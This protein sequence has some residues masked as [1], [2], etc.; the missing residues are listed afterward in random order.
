MASLSP[1]VQVGMLHLP[2]WV[3]V[4]F[5][6]VIIYFS[7]EEWKMLEKWQKDLYWKVLKDNY[8]V[9]VLVG[10]PVTKADVLAWL[11][12]HECPNGNGIQQPK[13]SSPSEIL[14]PSNQRL[15]QMCHK[16][17]IEQVGSLQELCSEVKADTALCYNITGSHSQR[18]AVSP[19]EYESG[20][21]G[22][23]SQLKSLPR[24]RPRVR[25]KKAFFPCSK[26]KKCFSSSSFLKV[27]QR[28]HLKE[29]GMYTHHG[30][31]LKTLHCCTDCGQNFHRYLD[32]LQHRKSHQMANPWLC[33]HCGD[34]FMSQSD[35]AMHEKGHL[36]E[37]NQDLA[38]CSQ[39]AICESSETGG[40]QMGLD[41]PQ[42]QEDDGKVRKLF[43]CVY[44][45][46]QFKVEMNLAV[47]YRYCPKGKLKNPQDAEVPAR[48]GSPHWASAH[49]SG[50]LWQP[51][52]PSQTSAQVI[53]PDPGQL[54]IQ[55]HR[56]KHQV[57]KQRISAEPG[58]S[59]SSVYSSGSLQKSCA[60]KTLHKC[61]ECGERFVYK[62]QLAAH[63]E[64][65]T[66]GKGSYGKSFAHKSSL[67][68][69]SQIHQEEAKL[70]GEN[71]QEN[72]VPAISHRADK[73]RPLFP[74][75][76][77]GNSFSKSYLRLHLAVHAGIRHK[78]LLCGKLFNYRSSAIGHL[79]Q[80]RKEG[81]FFP[82]PKCERR[83]GIYCSCRMKKVRITPPEPSTQVAKE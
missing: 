83:G 1:D 7:R 74:C 2:P 32:F 11:E 50:D 72:L 40:S 8:E 82:C 26:C 33:T 46:L 54:V 62:W 70:R 64:S 44:C 53:C 18:T 61:Q 20:E 52:H 73:E 3:P 16:E 12:K 45:K 30:N 29:N 17:G 71:H 49:K 41:D 14:C 75:K 69:H 10:H 28:T 48:Q 22:Q 80:H 58:G 59:A 78:C 4:V 47:H 15:P 57:E 42:Q 55:T 31:T 9:L 37:A 19:R 66:G 24:T 79:K 39:N 67:W 27:H 65:H 34:V 35:L 60:T 77:C 6:D 21:S 13:T 43:S 56:Q 25:I 5:E 81:P 68:N 63:L 36:E 76:E 51:Q 38:S 23:K